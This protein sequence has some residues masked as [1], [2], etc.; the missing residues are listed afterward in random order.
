MLSIDWIITVT[1]P[2]EIVL[3]SEK[4]PEIFFKSF[5]KNHMDRIKRENVGTDI[6]YNEIIYRYIR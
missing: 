3:P 6:K 2:E 4:P 1:R 5:E